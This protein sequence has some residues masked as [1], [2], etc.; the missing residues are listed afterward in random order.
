MNAD[1]YRSDL[2]QITKKIIG[3]AHRVSNALGCGILEKVY[4]NALT[5]ELHRAGLFFERQRLIV[6]RYDN[7]PVGGFSIDLLMESKVIVELKAA[8]AFDEVHAAQCMNYL[9]AAGVKVCLL[10]NFGRPR[11][12]VRRIVSDF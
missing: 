8:K 7:I 9:R 1:E 11:V 12:Q 10:I 3:C 2:D 6:D 5:I 4:E